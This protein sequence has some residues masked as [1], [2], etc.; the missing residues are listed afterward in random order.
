MG[1]H[2]KK[3]SDR[4]GRNTPDLFR[5]SS[6]VPAKSPNGRSRREGSP[7]KPLPAPPGPSDSILKRGSMIVTSGPLRPHIISP[8]PQEFLLVTGTGATDPGVGMFVNLEG[9]VTRSTLEFGRYPEAV[10]SD[11]R[12]VDVDL[13]PGNAEEAEDGYV[14]AVISKDTDDKTQYGLEIQRWDL[15][16]G[17]SASEKSWLDVPDSI[18]E[19]GRSKVGVR[20]VTEAAQFS[21]DEVVQK[22]RI[23]RFR[24]FPPPSFP[25]RSSSKPS[26]T[27]EHNKHQSSTYM[28]SEDDEERAEEELLFAKRLGRGQSRIVV[29]SGDKIWLAARNPLVLR[30]EAQMGNGAYDEALMNPKAGIITMSQVINSI[31]GREARTEIEFLSL[32]Y[33]R[34]R[35]G[36][37]LLTDLISRDSTSND[38]EY[39]AA[40]EAI[41]E[42]ALDPRVVVALSP[43]LRGEV[44]EGKAGIWI[45]AGIRDVAERFLAHPIS[46]A[47][48][49]D[50]RP[51]VLQFYRR[52]LGACRKQKGFGSTTDETEKFNTVDAALLLVLLQLDKDSPT[53]FGKRGSSRSELH[54]VVDHGVECFDRAV[55]ILEDHKRLYVLSRLYQSRKLAGEVLATWRRIVEGEMDVG[56]EF[57][58]GEQ[59]VRD[60][61]TIIRNAK[62][63][64]EYGV[65]LASRNPKLGVQVFADERSRVA[66]EP[67]NVVE[68]LRSGAPG[69]VKE[70]LEYLVFAK[71]MNE[72]GTELIAYYLDIVLIELESSAEARDVL[73]LGYKTYRALSSPKPTYRQFI[74]EN[75]IDADWWRARL[76]LLQLL[77]GTPEVG[78][79]R[80]STADAAAAD[81]DLPSI[82]GRIEPYRDLLVPE[83]IIL[84]GRQGRHAQALRLLVHGLGDYD[85]AINYCLAGGSSIYHPISGTLLSS[86]K[87]V[88]SVN[89]NGEDSQ[90]HLFDTLLSLFLALPDQQNCID[91]T[92]NLLSRFGSYFDILD[93]LNRV[94]EGWGVAVI[95][96]F[97][98]SRCREIVT[99]RNETMIVRALRGSEN[100][101]VAEEFI[102]RVDKLGFTI[103]GVE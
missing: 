40:Q 23:A 36:L 20:S 70:Y 10:V 95:D 41:L 99:E 71:G 26:N 61:L 22:L 35:A 47:E 77:G 31:R 74:A 102:D 73:S 8:S 80:G 19:A 79:R 34:Q 86:N 5:D 2:R 27:S 4:L 65:W 25:P 87:S 96:T 89:T 68:I 66:F 55:D 91:Q 75:G 59:R 51:H 48:S 15:D 84:D 67:T 103:E 11:G 76:R 100:I 16:A 3:S 69:A 17:E 33:I 83:L 97:L 62:L 37:L 56:G 94:P 28:K 32:G 9:E 60:Y 58:D 44:V 98:I 54:D 45:P 90:H 24:P 38:A 53:G 18:T 29:W 42:G 7:D 82:L 88:R 43:R 39:N 72:Y 57:T 52:F 93:V 12:G 13:S 101:Q 30:L 6:P 50:D 21:F 92:S 78:A 85:T 14:L 49:W 81:Y 64:E 63:V 46:D 1:H